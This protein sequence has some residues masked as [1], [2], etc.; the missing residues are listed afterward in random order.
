MFA[1]MLFFFFF[2]GFV[3][4]FLP[5]RAAFVQGHTEFLLAVVRHKIE[6]LFR[7]SDQEY[8]VRIFLCHAASLKMRSVG[9]SVPSYW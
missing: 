1:K 6:G 2:E 8:L 7:T 3:T 5:D 4:V 9:R